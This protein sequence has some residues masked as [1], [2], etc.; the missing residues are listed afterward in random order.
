MPIKALLADFYGTLVR[1]N[2]GLVRDLA[3]RICEASPL[4]ANPGDVANYWWETNSSLYRQHS[5]PDWLS[6]AQIDKEA[7]DEV[8]ERFEAHISV[9]E[10]LD[11]I[12]QSW[13]KPD[14]FS[15]TRVFMSRLPLPLC[16]VANGDRDTLAGALAFGQLEVQAAV[17]SEDARS[18]K[19][20]LGIFFH[21]LK[22]MGI[23]AD[24]ALFIGDSIYYDIQPAQKAGMYTAWVNRTGRSLGARVL[25]DVTC[26][27]LQQLRGMI[28]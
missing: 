1:E 15:D 19:P 10:M 20:D 17:T 9:Q 18:Y 4:A 5:G 21:A 25:P 16:V 3:R 14:V 11:E 7:L 26:D 23:K 6:L 12:V 27:N 22:I 8:V 13:Q 24:E 28:K 2:E